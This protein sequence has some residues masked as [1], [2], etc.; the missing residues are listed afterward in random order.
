MSSACSGGVFSYP[1]RTDKMHLNTDNL[2]RKNMLPN[3]HPC[4][5]NPVYE[6]RTISDAPG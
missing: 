4:V 3:F 5:E 2:N 6:I 1:T